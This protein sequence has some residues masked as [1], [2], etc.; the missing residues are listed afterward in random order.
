MND[1]LNRRIE[2][3]EK[4]AIE[5]GYDFYPMQYEIV[6]IEIMLEVMSYGLPTRARHWTYGQ[7]YE[8]QKMTGEMG[9]SKV[10]ELVLNNDPSYAF[11]LD[12]NSD[13]ANTM[14]CAHVLG[15]SAFFKHN[16]LF[17]QTDNK[18]V[19]KAA[20]RAARI[21][22]YINKYGLDKVERIMN[23]GFSMDKQI[24]WHKGIH[25]KPQRTQ[26]IKK[27]SKTLDK[28][29]D[30][31]IG[32]PKKKVAFKNLDKNILFS[33]EY[34]LLWFLINY[35]KLADWEKDI[36]EIIREESYYFYPQYKTKIMNE[37]FASY[38]HAHLMCELDEISPAEFI[39]YTKIHERVVQPGG[40]KFNINPYFLGF[41][42]FN[43]I[44]RRWDEKF[45]KGESEINGFQ[46]MLQVVE[47]DDDI[48][49]IRGYLTKEIT[50]DLELFVYSKKPQSDGS[51]IVT[52]ES[53]DLDDIK[54]Y[55][56][57]DIY[58]YRS[59]VVSIS[60]ASKSSLELEHD[61]SHVGTLDQKHLKVIMGYLYDLWGAPVDLKTVDDDGKVIYL[62]Y[63]EEGPS[64]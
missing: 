56:C 21:D 48:S 15:H 7:S 12:T 54:E 13:V 29:F 52:I 11:L 49:F 16:Y 24:D 5:F 30:D 38:A 53:K 36:L 19:Y 6:P 63:D 33:K 23:I 42:I 61:S 37:G 59:P 4:M 41:T 39:E 57:K 26:K 27:L 1:L 43:D 51:T 44:K 14:V 3:L 22:D 25:R 62:T 50:E 34:D 8:Y 9:Q 28:S 10:Y 32:T 55:L 45:A 40:N 64:F 35:G 47:E 17:K 20:E 2:K 60:H 31:L 18:M 58:G 46:K